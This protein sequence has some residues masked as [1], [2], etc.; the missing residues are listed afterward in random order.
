MTGTGCCFPTDPSH[1]SGQLYGS[2]LQLY[3]VVKGRVGVTTL[4]T[5]FQTIRHL[6]VTSMASLNAKGNIF[7]NIEDSSS[8]NVAEIIVVDNTQDVSTTKAFFSCEMM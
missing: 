2:C 4:Q 3:I 1:V 5:P 8:T 7:Q 6:T